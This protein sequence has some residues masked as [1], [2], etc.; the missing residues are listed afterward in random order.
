MGESSLGTPAHIWPSQPSCGSLDRAATLPPAVTRRRLVNSGLL[1][2]GTAVLIGPTAATAAS[3]VSVWGLDPDGCGCSVCSACRSHAANKIFASPADADAG[4]AHPHC[5]CS[6]TALSSVEPHV[7]DVLFVTGGRRSS[8]DR[9]WQWVQAALRSS[10]PI[11]PPAAPGTDAEPVVVLAAAAEDREVR[12]RQ[13]QRPVGSASLRSA[14]IRRLTPGHRVLFVQ[15]STDQTVEADISLVRDSRTLARRH[16]PRI[17]QRRTIEIPLKRSVARGPA[18][19]RIR[20]TDTSG[21][22]QTVTRMV[23]VP[24][25]EPRSAAVR[26]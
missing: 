4:R 24:A 3:T 1:A 26:A 12:R 20:L 14:W 9:R 19:V 15:I 17:S 6:V 7:F 25:L 8:V 13:R 18:Q 22:R 10:A 23:S 11:P 16:V 5:R 21:Q 2:F